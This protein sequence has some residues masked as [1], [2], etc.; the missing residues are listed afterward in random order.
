MAS[1]Y[2]LPEAPWSRIQDPLP[3]RKESAGRT[4][5]AHRVLVNG[6][7]WGGARGSDW[8]ERY[9]QYKSVHKRLARWAAGGVW[10]QV[11]RSLVPGTGGENRVPDD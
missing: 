6:L 4:A 1:H 3:G 8:P 5:A 10:E 9:G 7:L 2:E 11:F